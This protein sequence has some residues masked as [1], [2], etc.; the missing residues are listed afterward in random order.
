MLTEHTISGTSDYN[1]YIQYSTLWSCISGALHRTINPPRAMPT[2]REQT[3]LLLPVRLNRPSLSRPAPLWE[4][5]G[6]RE[7]W[8]RYEHRESSGQVRSG[9]RIA[10]DIILIIIII[11]LFLL[12]TRNHRSQH[13]SSENSVPKANRAHR[14]DGA[15]GA[16]LVDL[17][18]GWLRKRLSRLSSASGWLTLRGTRSPTC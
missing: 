13:T 8:D 10:T 9:P 12:Q 5:G 16:R 17:P 15:A 1:H 11:F 18:V 4:D 7:G 14:A 2:P 6:W 3:S